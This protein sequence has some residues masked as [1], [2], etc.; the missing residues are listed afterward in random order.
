[1]ATVTIPMQVLS[2]GVIEQGK[3]SGGREWLRRTFQVFDITFQKSGQ[4]Q[5]YGDEEKLN[6][7]KQGGAYNAVL[8]GAAGDYARMNY[9]VI[10]LIP[11]NQPKAA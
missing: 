8:S 2:I 1:M 9:E 4:I 10:D 5:I 3:S 7:F 6:T 11:A